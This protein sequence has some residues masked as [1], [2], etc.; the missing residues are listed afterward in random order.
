MDAEEDA[1]VAARIARGEKILPP[2][3]QED[4]LDDWM[5]AEGVPGLTTE[6]MRA[7][8]GF[9]DDVVVDNLAVRAPRDRAI[10]CALRLATDTLSLVC[11]WPSPPPP[12]D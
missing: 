12:V 1:D 6:A 3:M 2:L 8:I 9:D 10:S 5:T 11:F 4:E 7:L